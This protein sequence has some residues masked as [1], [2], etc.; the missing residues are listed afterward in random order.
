M[1]D[2]LIHGLPL[3]GSIL[4]FMRCLSLAREHR[5][6]HLQQHNRPSAEPPLVSIIVP[7]RNEERTLPYLI[8]SIKKLAFAKFEVIVADDSSSD[9]TGKLAREAGFTVVQV[10]DKP[11]GWL[12]KPN[13]CMQAQR[14]AS[15]DY[16]LFTDADVILHPHTLSRALAYMQEQQLDFMS[17]LPYHSG[18]TLWEKLMGPFHLVMLAALRPDVKPNRHHSFF[19]I[20]Q[21]LLIK[22]SCYDAI[23]AHATARTFVCEDLV[24]ASQAIRQGFQ[25]G[26]YN[27][28]TLF[29]V[30]MYG[31]L[32]EFIKGWR[33]N[34]R[35]GTAF[36]GSRVV[37]EIIGFIVGGLSLFFPPYGITKGV[38]ALIFAAA[39]FLH[40]KR[41]GNFSPLGVVLYP[42]ALAVFILVGALALFDSVLR[43]PIVWKDRSFAATK[44][45]DR[46]TGAPSSSENI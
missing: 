15:G 8:A 26:V 17:A 25:Y 13:A 29:D 4:F 43:R 21:F 38:A 39:V 16:L 23:G 7:A 33:R 31:S 41:L 45:I 2:F 40:Q 37:L 12:G 10:K 36:F 27:A 19:A 35:V 30:R 5:E 3:I 20:G 32:G 44:A 11:D 22:R 18:F 9:A 42:F 28:A 6:I 24:L 46:L 14:L 1:L 34:F